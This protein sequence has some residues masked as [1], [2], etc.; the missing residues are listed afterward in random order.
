MRH[1]FV[2]RLLLQ[3]TAW[4]QLIIVFAPC[5]TDLLRLIER[6]EPVLIQALLPQPAV[7]ALDERIIGGLARAA[8]F[9]LHSVAVGP[10]V[11]CLRD[12]L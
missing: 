2:P 8:E 7:E 4:A 6:G 11:H 5:F 1:K 10:L 12:Q 3:R 9:Q